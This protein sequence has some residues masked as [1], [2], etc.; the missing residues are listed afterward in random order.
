MDGAFLQVASHLILGGLLTMMSGGAKPNL[1]QIGSTIPYRRLHQELERDGLYVSWVSGAMSM[2]AV[3]TA[4]ATT[5]SVV[6]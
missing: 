4:F 3:I 2:A 1:L 6:G 5:T